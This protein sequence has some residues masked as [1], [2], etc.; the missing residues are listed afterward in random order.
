MNLQWPSPDTRIRIARKSFIWR[1]NAQSAFQS[2]A[3]RG[4]A[5]RASAHGS[6]GCY[7]SGLGSRSAARRLP[8]ARV[9]QDSPAPLNAS[10]DSIL[11][12]WMTE[13]QVAAAS[14]AVMKDGRIV[15][16]S[17]YGGM[18][19]NS[20]ARIASLSKAITAVCIARLVDQGRLSFTTT[21]GAVLAKTFQ[22]VRP[23]G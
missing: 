17:G 5:S 16:T 1:S 4:A 2:V 10:F 14:L 12:G 13:H 11:K 19:A 9:S 8:K 7:S 6:P 20:P 3:A 18:N 21:L 15:A 22:A 23:T